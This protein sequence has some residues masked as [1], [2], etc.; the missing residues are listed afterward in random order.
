MLCVSHGRTWTEYKEFPIIPLL[1]IHMSSFSGP[2][3]IAPLSSINLNFFIEFSF[4]FV[5]VVVV[6]D[7]VNVSVEVGVTVGKKLSSLLIF[8]GFFVKTCF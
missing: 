7:G 2:T 1:Q 6:V 5:V 8:S 3:I 4:A